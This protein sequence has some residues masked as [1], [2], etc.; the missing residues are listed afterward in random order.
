MAEFGNAL[1]AIKTST[2][3][4]IEMRHIKSERLKKLEVELTDLE[5]WLKLGL[6]PKK[7]VEKHK[8]ENRSGSS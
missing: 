8:Q 7:D 5:Q 1:S 6:V 3:D 4:E 2:T